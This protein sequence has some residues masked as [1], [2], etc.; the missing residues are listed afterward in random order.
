MQFSFAPCR[1]TPGRE[2]T[3]GV[4]RESPALTLEAFPAK[5][6]AGA[7]MSF[8]LLLPQWGYGSLPQKQA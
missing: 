1:L 3:V 4:Q 6:A 7:A 2:S 8:E 5:G